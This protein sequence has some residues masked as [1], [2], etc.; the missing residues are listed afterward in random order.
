MGPLAVVDAKPLVGD[1]APLRQRF[2]EMRVEH[3]GAVAPIEA[4][5]ARVLVWP[6]W[7]DV[8]NNHAVGG[9]P[10]DEGLPAR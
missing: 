5:D 6:A 9:T 7:L 2:E 1:H 4:F 10:L 8:V 3:F